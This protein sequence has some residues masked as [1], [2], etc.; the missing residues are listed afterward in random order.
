MNKTVRRIVR[1]LNRTTQASYPPGQGAFEFMN[2]GRLVDGE[3][4][5]T[6]IQKFPGSMTGRDVPTYRFK[7][8]IS[9]GDEEIGRIDLRV[10]NTERIVRFLGHI[11]YHVNP[12][13]RGNRYAARATRLLLPL[14]FSHNINPIWIT[15]N[16]ENLASRRTC[17]LLGADLVEIVDTPRNSDF[18]RAGDKQKCRYRIER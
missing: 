7:M 9:G 8:M 12:K 18:Y 2:P 13:Y 11:G 4:V 16:P 17:E 1:I 15:C 5:L 3:L 10:A 14:A 6:L